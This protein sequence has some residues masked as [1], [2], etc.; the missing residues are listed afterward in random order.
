MLKLLKITFGP[1]FYLILGDLI[2][3]NMPIYKPDNS[4]DYKKLRIKR[5][6]VW[7]QEQKAE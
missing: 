7:I 5:F 1:F 3:R 6:D 4:I 2:Q